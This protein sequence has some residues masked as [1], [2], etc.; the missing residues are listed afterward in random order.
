MGTRSLKRVLDDCRPERQRIKPKP[1]TDDKVK[2][3]WP[4]TRVNVSR[5]SPCEAKR[6]RFASLA[7]AA[8]PQRARLQTGF[9]N[10]I[11]VNRTLRIAAINV[12]F[13]RI[14]PLP[15]S[16][17]EGPECAPK[18]PLHCRRER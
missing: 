5:P 8:H 7:A 11:D 14:S 12:A 1:G 4:P 13:G 3:A 18:P 9:F 10:E 17:S 16:P 2:S 6:R 15:E